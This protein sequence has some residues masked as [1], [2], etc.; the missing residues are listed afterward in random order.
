MPSA[1]GA[2]SSLIAVMASLAVV[3]G[4]LLLVLWVMRRAMPGGTPL[5]AACVTD[6]STLRMLATVSSRPCSALSVA[7]LTA[8]RMASPCCALDLANMSMSAS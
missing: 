8:L 4:L 7:A 3:I 2:G 5:E 1:T 6:F